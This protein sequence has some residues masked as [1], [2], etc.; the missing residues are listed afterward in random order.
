MIP[1]R[2]VFNHR[3]WIYIELA[4]TRAHSCHG[5][6]V[7]QPP[8]SAY[9]S[10]GRAPM[11]S[12]FHPSMPSQPLSLLAFPTEIL[13]FQVLFVLAFWSFLRL[14]PVHLL[15]ISPRRIYFSK[16]PNSVFQLS[17]KCARLSFFF[18]FLESETI[19]GINM[20]NNLIINWNNWLLKMWI[21]L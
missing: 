21:L 18:F 12:P 11:F 7:Y 8:S 13:P 14:P 5:P 15:S 2:T 3:K 16:L 17:R 6:L 4:I 1:S 20:W 10:R 9:G 19:G